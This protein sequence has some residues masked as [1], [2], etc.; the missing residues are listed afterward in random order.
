MYC[1]ARI[2][3][4]SICVCHG[5]RVLWPADRVAYRLHFEPSSIL[6][7]PSSELSPCQTARTGRSPPNQARRDARADVTIGSHLSRDRLYFGSVRNGPGRRRGW[8]VHVTALAA[9]TSTI[10]LWHVVAPPGPGVP[11]PSPAPCLAGRRR[12]VVWVAQL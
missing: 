11:R 3:S 2:F 5:H 10:G 7:P 4:H 1:H 8:P 6:H 12:G 9:R